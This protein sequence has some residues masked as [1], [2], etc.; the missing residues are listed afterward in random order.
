MGNSNRDREMDNLAAAITKMRL[1]QEQQNRPEDPTAT[2]EKARR[3]MM[4]A[5]KDPTQQSASPGIPAAVGALPPTLDPGILGVKG[6]GTAA[7]SPRAPAGAIARGKI[8]D[9]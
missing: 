7:S 6:T 9:A 3:A 2:V 5:F 1:Q 4:V 8:P